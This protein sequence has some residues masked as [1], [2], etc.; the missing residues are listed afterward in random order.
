MADKPAG[1]FYWKPGLRGPVSERIPIDSGTPA[2]APYLMKV[3]LN[4]DQMNLSL[5]ILEK[6]FPL[7]E[8]NTV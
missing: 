5:L 3:P 2:P 8:E 1:Y 6:R 4:E 7:P